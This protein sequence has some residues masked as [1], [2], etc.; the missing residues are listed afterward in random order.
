MKKQHALAL[1][2]AVMM[3]ATC[4]FAETADDPV[5]VT[6]GN[7]IVLLS[8]A[9]AFFDDLYSQ[10][11]EYYASYGFS[12]TD[13]DIAYIRDEAVEN[14]V[15]YALMDEKAIELGLDQ[16]TEE[17][18]EEFRALVEQDFNEGI[19]A[20]AEYYGLSVEEAIEDV[21]QYGIT[22]E[23]QYESMLVSLP[24]N[25]LHA[26]I[27]EGIDVSDEEI[28][29]EYDTYVETSKSSY[30]NDAG[31][32]E[33]N[34]S[35]YGYESYYIPE[36]FR[37]IKHILLNAPEELT[38]R[39]SEASGAL[40]AA[41]TELD[42]L[43]A[44]LY[45]QENVTEEADTDTDAEERRDPEEIQAD[46]DA[47]QAECDTLEAAYEEL[48]G[49]IIPALQE[50]IDSIGERL[51]AGESF[52]DLIVEFGQD[53]GMATNAEGYHVHKDSI[54]WDTDF[55]DTAMALE[56]VNDISKPLLTDFGVHIIQYAGDVEGGPVPITE[57]TKESIRE[58]LLSTAQE[59]A[60]Y[61]QVY[62][63]LEEY[64]VVRNSD[65]IVLPAAAA[66][67]TDAGDTKAE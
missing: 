8:E 11:N 56:N 60:F 2:L 23:S 6:L 3:A 15:M 7:Q 13:E 18:L 53:P 12:L 20:Y 51:A 44:E 54:L 22:L 21:A 38:A 30:E 59:N 52:D 29:A 45:A 19:K 50:T 46:I 36:G 14:L 26:Y 10:Y 37:L 67:D 17:E 33:L 63:W 40:D 57:A 5:V 32:Y 42:T 24:L 61:E 27:V 48:R 9:Q 47:K 43:N 1:L 31:M 34:T 16:H 65:L 25:K 58:T 66:G 64:E 49:Q 35:Y 41:L 4:A 28:Q 62:A 55:R 39:I